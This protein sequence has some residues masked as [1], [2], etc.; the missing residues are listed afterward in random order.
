MNENDERN[1]ESN[2]ILN[3]QTSGLNQDNMLAH[4]LFGQLLA[5]QKGISR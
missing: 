3:K 1:E 4:N 2:D 5:A